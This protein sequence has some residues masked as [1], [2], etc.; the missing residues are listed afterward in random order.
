MEKFHKM[1]YNNSMLQSYGTLARFYKKTGIPSVSST[2]STAP[3]TT[4]ASVP[5]TMTGPAM[6]R[7]YSQRQGENGGLLIVPR[8]G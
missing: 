3:Y 8:F 1:L 2:H 7:P 5:Y 4:A 6:D